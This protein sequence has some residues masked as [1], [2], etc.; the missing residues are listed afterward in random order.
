M[1]ADFDIGDT[2]SYGLDD[3]STFMAADD[4]ECTFRVL[5]GESVC[6]GMAYL[7]YQHV[8]AKG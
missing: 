3:S 6:V 4:G 5:S 7:V 1:V 8:I 2:L